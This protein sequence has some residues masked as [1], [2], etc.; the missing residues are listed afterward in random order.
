MR[1]NAAT[2]ERPSVQVMVRASRN[3]YPTADT[4]ITAVRDTLTG[5]TDEEISGVR[6]LRVNQ[7][8]SINHIGTDD[9]DRPGFTLSLMTVVER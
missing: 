9:N 5:I 8:S 6:F 7:N 3:D 1:D 4:L 2:L